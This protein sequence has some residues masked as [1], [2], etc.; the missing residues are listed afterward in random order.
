M[1]WLLLILMLV[2]SASLL[3]AQKTSEL[4]Y[5]P[6]FSFNKT[7]NKK[8]KYYYNWRMAWL[9]VYMNVVLPFLAIMS[10]VGLMDYKALHVV[11]Y[12]P[13]VIQF[14]YMAFCVSNALL[15]RFIDK[16]S[17]VL[18]LLANIM[19]LVFIIA[20]SGITWI[21]TAPLA[22]GIVLANLIYFIKRRE[23]FFSTA[24]ELRERY[25]L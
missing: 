18:N 11:S 2:S 15:F 3:S 12:L 17:F 16:T 1:V 4:P 5:T 25:T 23:L 20:N 19:F 22:A 8:M 10:L 7:L 6:F 21:L 13:L 14:F 9:K 24:K